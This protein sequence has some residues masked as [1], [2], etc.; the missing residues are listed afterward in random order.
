MLL[1]QTDSSDHNDEVTKTPKRRRV[2]NQTSDFE[3]YAA[4]DL[5]DLPESPSSCDT[6]LTQ[7]N[8]PKVI[9]TPPST[10]NNSLVDSANEID[11]SNLF[12]NDVRDLVLQPPCKCDGEIIFFFVIIIIINVNF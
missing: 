7:E 2:E 6:T 9:V 10:T 5:D 1:Y 4:R 8:M 3:Y 11:C 12:I